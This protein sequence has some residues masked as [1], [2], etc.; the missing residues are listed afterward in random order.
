[1]ILKYLGK[2]RTDNFSFDD[3]ISDLNT[4]KVTAD[5][6]EASEDIRTNNE[7]TR[8]SNESTRQSNETVRIN[9]ENT[10]GSNESIRQ[11]NETARVSSE[12][13]RDSA[14]TSRSS[15]EALRVSSENTRNSNESTRTTSESARISNENT[16]VSAETNRSNAETLRANSE[17]TRINSENTRTANESTRVS[18]ENTRTTNESNR[19]S[20]ETTRSS[21]ETTRQGNEAA[22]V[23]KLQ[24]ITEDSILTKSYTEPLNMTTSLDGNGRVIKRT[25]SRADGTK[26]E[27]VE[28]NSFDS[29]NNPQ[30][31]IRKTYD[32]QGKGANKT[33][34]ALT[35][36]AINEPTSDNVSISAYDEADVTITR[37]GLAINPLTG[38]NPTSI[39]TVAANTP[40]T[41]SNGVTTLNNDNSMLQVVGNKSLTTFT[42][43]KTETYSGNTMFVGG[44]TT[45]TNFDFFT[46][47]SNS[48]AECPLKIYK[49]EVDLANLP[50]PT[51]NWTEITNQSYLDKLKAQNEIPITSTNTT[52]RTAVYNG[53]TLIQQSASQPAIRDDFKNKI[54]G[55]T[56]E[57]PNVSKYST[58]QTSLQ[59]PSAL[60]WSEAQLGASYDRIQ[61]LNDGNISSPSTSIVNAIPQQLFS[62]NIVEMAIRKYGNA[63]GTTLAER[64]AWCKANIDS[65]TANAYIYGSCPSGNVAY[66]TPWKATNSSWDLTYFA[67]ITASVPT[68]VPYTLWNGA[69][70]DSNGFVHFLAYTDAASTTS[71]RM[72]VLT[73]HGMPNNGIIENT[74]RSAIQITTV[75]TNNT[76]IL[77]API[78]G[79]SSGDTIVKYGLTTIKNTEVGTTET[80]I[81]ITNHGLS[82]GDY[83]KNTTRGYIYKKITA[84][85]DVNTITITSS[86]TGQTNG[87]SIELYHLVGTQIAESTV[88]PSTIYTDYISLDVQFKAPSTDYYVLVPQNPR[89]DSVSGTNYDNVVLLQKTSPYNALEFFTNNSIEIEVTTVNKASALMVECDLTQLCNIYFGGS[90]AALKAALKGITVDAWAQGSGSNGGVLTNGVFM[91]VLRDSEWNTSC[92]APN[93]TSSIAKM[94]MSGLNQYEY[95]VRINSSN[96][97]Y[98][99]IASQYPSDSIIPSQVA[100]DY[101]NIKVD[102]GR[103]PDIVSPINVNLPKYWAIVVKGW[104]PKLMNNKN[105]VILDIN[106]GLSDRFVI[107]KD[108]SNALQVNGSVSNFFDT[109][110]KV[111]N[112]LIQCLVG[113]LKIWYL[114]NNSTVSYVN[115]S[116]SQYGKPYK[117]MIGSNLMGNGDQADAFMENCTLLDLTNKPTGYTDTEALAILNGT[118]QGFENPELFDINAVSL[119]PN[120][121]LKDGV[122]TLSA[123]GNFQTNITLIPVLPNN[124]YILNF[125]GTNGAMINVW[126]KYNGT[127][128]YFNGVATDTITFTTQ[129]NC[130]IIYLEITNNTKGVGTFTFSNISLKR[131]D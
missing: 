49:Q 6:L 51:T 110:F 24:R 3:L 104:A 4:I 22:R 97:I 127:I 117:M 119:H 7:S 48:T 65:I 101:I 60:T 86:I 131:K 112:F 120:A 84:I 56:V 123:T 126:S 1:M 16:R 10:R 71:D 14:E 55:S 113:T 66:L 100:L 41:I 98:I 42:T 5:T 45:N 94:T 54:V 25:Y 58:S 40:V 109:D 128:L 59:T 53:Q 102:I 38:Y 116:C 87:D 95:S 27:E 30:S 26:S 114:K 62:F 121:S 76:L 115:T 90:N 118:A 111:C 12:N 57:N 93:T 105:Q 74:T 79:Q 80:T 13:L 52:N 108:T 21:N 72:L 33:V 67:K 19:V 73:N 64:I 70:I 88:I 68:L 44:D 81:K 35:Y 20:A 103:T 34:H 28:R 130:N 69:Y 125:N 99:L 63:I 8:L 15:A 18:S 122:I 92:I 29:N 37:N 91:K 2:V 47:V 32:T 50:N 36:N 9:N 124:R 75:G 77:Y 107:Y 46:K 31:L 78:V 106:N 85:P 23:Q 96:K 17:S 83:I 39:T 43:G 61:V 11:S 129:N 82:V 89:R